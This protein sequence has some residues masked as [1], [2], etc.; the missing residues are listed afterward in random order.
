MTDHPLPRAARS[1]S[2]ADPR[3]TVRPALLVLAWLFCCYPA[4]AAL[5]TTWTAQDVY[6]YGF[7]IPVIAVIWVWHGRGKLKSTPVEP[8]L[9]SGSLFL[10]AAA[11]L[12][13]GG[14]RSSTV[15][16]QELALVCVLSALVLLVL[17]RRFLKALGAPL[18]YLILAVPVLDPVVEALHP[19]FQLFAAWTAEPILQALHVPVLRIG[20]FLELP[21]VTLE[22][23][24][25]CSG[26]RYLVSTIVLAVPLVFITQKSGPRRAL[27]FTCALIIGIIANPLRVA[28]IGL[29]AH[30]GSGDVHGP[31][32]LLQ[33]YAVYLAGMLLLF[34]IARVLQRAPEGSEAGSGPAGSIPRAAPDFKK[35]N[36]VFLVSI[37]VLFA[38]GCWQHAYQPEPVALKK[39]FNDFPRTI[40][41]WEAQKETAG[42]KRFLAGADDRFNKVYRNRAGR[43]LELT[44]SYFEY[45][46][47][48]KKLISN[49]SRPYTDAGAEIEMMNSGKRVKIRK[50]ASGT[51]EQTSAS[52]SWYRINGSTFA[53]RY[54]A[55]LQTFFDALF[56]GK[57]N[58]ALITIAGPEDHGAAFAEQLLPVLDDFIP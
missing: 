44:I 43:A 23:A 27:L 9:L 47:Q 42:E 18:A 25:A 30:Y 33:G 37:A 24:D 48:G 20:R 41:D 31:G 52:V 55:K 15:I 5:V 22:V 57:T 7:L 3:N 8:S 11:L 13:A 4:L 40:G 46:D 1:F 38:A 10:T 12:L 53:N 26:V 36:A 39:S 2:G 6:S 58:G 51:G 21:S 54:R 49:T 14:G 50:T 34:G 28:L 29:W 17:G 32:H 16:V 45:Q 56:Y 19:P 35:L